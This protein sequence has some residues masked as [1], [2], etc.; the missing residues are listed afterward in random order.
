MAWL[1]N[2]RITTRIWLLIGLG[3]LGIASIVAAYL[4]GE[5]GMAE[6]EK[7]YA[8]SRQI[9]SDAGNADKG[10]LRM[11]AASL[12]FLDS[13]DITLVPQY[14]AFWNDTL[15]AVTGIEAVPGF[16]EIAGKAREARQAIDQLRNG[17][18]D[19]VE[20]VKVLGLTENDGLQGTLRTAVRSVEARVTQ[21]GD[22]SL[23]NAMLF[24]RRLEKDYMLRDDARYVADHAE[25]VKTARA[26]LKESA[27]TPDVQAELSNLIDAYAAGFQAYVAGQ[28]ALKATL[29]EIGRIRPVVD[30]AVAALGDA[31]RARQAAAR[32]ELNAVRATTRTVI[33]GAAGGLLALFLAGAVVLS[34]SITGPVSRLNTAMSQLAAGNLDV[35]VPSTD[36]RDEIGAMARAMLVFQEGAVERKRLE[37]AQ[38]EERAAKERRALAVER[39]VEEFE[40]AASGRLRTVAAAATE[41]ESTARS[42]SD[43]AGNAMEQASSSADASQQ[44][45]ANVQT[46]AAATE[47]MTSSIAEI[48]RQV[49]ESAEVT[50]SAVDEAQNTNAIV[51]SLNESAQRIGDVVKLIQ[52]IASQTNLLALNATIEAARAG[53]AGKGFAVV[54][55]EVKNLANQ[56]AKATEDITA[57]ISGMQAETAGVV[58]A[59]RGITDTIGRVNHIASAIAAAVEEQ[60]ATTGEISRNVQQAASA[61]QSVSSSIQTVTQAAEQTGAASSQVLSAAQELSVQAEG[62]QSEVQRFLSG[63]R[64]A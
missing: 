37:A 23:L 49:D 59:I 24:L 5:A 57:Q 60:N 50:R 32:E 54:A 7:T 52:D 48:A 39:L 53:E 58:G 51:T 44:T 17:F 22:L 19:A 16:P 18:A 9:E 13:R 41:L 62:L 29:E 63:I 56:T 12:Q 15:K 11:R 1:S 4:V 55:Q 20:K 45:S 42:M 34:R 33:L 3:A 43:V 64:A 40:R 10:L 31:A 35:G 36:S 28:K 27:L 47:E 30:A 25:A 46:V 2:I 38:A 21:A 14:E 8:A 6:K 26:R 61:T